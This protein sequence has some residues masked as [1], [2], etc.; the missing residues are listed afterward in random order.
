VQLRQERPARIECLVAATGRRVADDR[1]DDDLGAVG[2]DAGRVAAQHHRQPVGRQA[3]AAQAEQVV[4]VERGRPD[5][6]RRPP[7]GRHRVGSVADPQSRQRVVLVLVNAHGRE[8]IAT[9]AR[10]GVMF[11]VP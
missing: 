5:A 9:I 6:H 7:L 3:H 2:R 1:V 10:A 4:L 8:H 11:T